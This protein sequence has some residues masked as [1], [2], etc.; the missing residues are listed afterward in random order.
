[1]S[2]YSVQSMDTTSTTNLEFCSEVIQFRASETP[3][4]ESAA[5]IIKNFIKPNSSREIKSLHKHI[6]TKILQDYS[7]IRE[8]FMFLQHH[9]RGV[10][11]NFSFIKSDKSDVKIEE[12]KTSPR[13]E[14]MPLSPEFIAHVKA[15]K[16]LR[17]LFDVAFREVKRWM[18]LNTWPSF[19]S[20]EFGLAAASWLKWMEYLSNF[21]Y[22]EQS[23]AAQDINARVQNN[24]YTRTTEKAMEDMRK[25]RNYFLS[26]DF[27]A[28]LSDLMS[29]EGQQTVR[30]QR[31]GEASP[32]RRPS[33]Q[34]RVRVHVQ[35]RANPSGIADYAEKDK[36]SRSANGNGGSKAQPFPLIVQKSQPVLARDPSSLY[37]HEPAGGSIYAHERGIEGSVVIERVSS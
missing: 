20:S 8:K 1:M 32:A 25:R 16:A 34:K 14:L 28:N 10:M 18:Y 19:R 11:Q 2:N 13:A 21:T 37:A 7:E 5:N 9:R 36:D 4:L 22:E 12:K 29:H 15:Q 3:L 30:K 31:R 24:F 33:P 17:S 6:R 27:D 23:W 26:R 35:A